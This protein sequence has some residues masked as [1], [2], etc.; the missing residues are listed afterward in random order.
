MELIEHFNPSED[1]RTFFSNSNAQRT[2][3]NLEQLRTLFLEVGGDES[4]ESN[5]KQEYIFSIVTQARVRNQERLIASLSLALSQRPRERTNATI[6]L[7][8]E[9]PKL[10]ITKTSEYH[11]FKAYEAK[12]I[13]VLARDKLDHVICTDDACTEQERKDVYT[14]KSKI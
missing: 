12:L 9:T 8:F 11:L 4:Y 14:I 2:N 10:H 6:S 7:K 3:L 1:L 5:R 13:S